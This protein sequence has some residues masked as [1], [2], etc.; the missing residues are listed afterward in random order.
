MWNKLLSDSFQWIFVINNH[1]TQPWVGVFTKENEMRYYEK[2][3]IIYKRLK[4]S[5]IQDTMTGKKFNDAK[6]F[7]M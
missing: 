1:R 3:R 5:N 6:Y 7:Y 2:Q 4:R